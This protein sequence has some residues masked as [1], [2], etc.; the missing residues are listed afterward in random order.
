MARA[1]ATLLLA[2]GL[3]ACASIEAARL[4][5]S[6]TVAL[7]RGDAVQAVADLEEATRLEPQASEIQN[8]LGLAYAAAGRHADAL[9]AF[10]QAVLLDCDNQAALRNLAAAQRPADSP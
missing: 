10:E 4:Y 8:H 3:A 9:R 5:G 6:G 1:A 2:M 7:D